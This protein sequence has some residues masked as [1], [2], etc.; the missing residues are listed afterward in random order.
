[1]NGAFG[2][3]N[4]ITPA[5][6]AIAKLDDNVSYDEGSVLELV[7][8]TMRLM[9]D[10]GIRA[11]DNVAVIGQGPAGLILLQEAKLLG[12]RATVAFDLI[13]SRLEMA[14]K[15]GADLVINP[16]KMSRE[17]I[18]Q[19]VA[20]EIGEIDLVVDAVGNSKGAN[21]GV[22]ILRPG[23]NC[24]IFGHATKDQSISM[25]DICL[26]NISMRGFDCSMDRTTALLNLAQRMVSEGKLQLKPLIT[27]HVKLDN[28]QDGL[29]LC[30][31]NASETLKV[32]A[33]IV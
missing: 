14:S 6:L 2:E 17:E 30:Q 32:I 25:R 21:L 9:Y 23:G 11:A 5:D 20:D 12:A 4:L 33:D 10:S 18:L 8:G 19:K 22:E 26:K 7:G 16:A 15:L 31:A 13:D 3:Y 1:M 27:H 28:L 29:D 24:V